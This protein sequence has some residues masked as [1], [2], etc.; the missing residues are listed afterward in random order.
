[1]C[2]PRTKYNCTFST[3]TAFSNAN[4]INI[5]NAYEINMHQKNNT[6][7]RILMMIRTTDMV[8]VLNCIRS[9]FPYVLQ[10]LLR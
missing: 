2:M 5:P 1:M 8:F 10:F 6:V 3:R 9:S 7:I 4:N